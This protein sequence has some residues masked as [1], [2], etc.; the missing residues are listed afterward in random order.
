MRIVIWMA[1]VAVLVGAVPSWGHGELGST[2]PAADS[3]VR[4]VPKVISIT[5]TEP[6]GPGTTVRVSDG[7]HSHLDYGVSRSDGVLEATMG[8]NEQG[9]P[10]RWQVRFKA[11][12]AIDGHTTR[13]KFGFTVRGRRQCHPRKPKGADLNRVGGGEGTIIK[14]PDPPDDGS[15]PIRLFV[16]GS[17]VL[18]GLAFAMRRIASR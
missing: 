16:I 5:L 3:I 13:G 6:P 14:N 17:L 4:K 1:I 2:D 10:G 11:V 15:F 7:C 8:A 18:I 12:S 9:E